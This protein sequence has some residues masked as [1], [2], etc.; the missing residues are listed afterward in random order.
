MK[1]IKYILPLF[2]TSLL[3]LYAQAQDNFDLKPKYPVE[4]DRETNQYG[5]PGELFADLK[6]GQVY[7]TMEINGQVWMT[8]NYSFNTNF[9]SPYYGP[10]EEW[11]YERLVDDKYRIVS[12]ET[13]R[14]YGRLYTYEAA[15]NSAPEGWRLPSIED[16]DQLSQSLGMNKTMEP[17]Q[18]FNIADAY[19]NFDFQSAGSKDPI[20]GFVGLGQ[21][22]LFWSEN[23]NEQNASYAK[24]V[25][26]TLKLVHG[27]SNKQSL[28]SVRYIKK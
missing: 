26:R 23:D 25:D 12:E 11:E 28:L 15:L 9:E 7:S 18:P 17:G 13:R 8:S 16:W 3:L 5:Q 14:K 27:E 4:M 10:G 22:A 19:Y 20:L 24:V 2:L 1:T 6:D 21:K